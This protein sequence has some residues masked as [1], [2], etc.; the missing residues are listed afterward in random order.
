MFENLFVRPLFKSYP[1]RLLEVN[2]GAVLVGDKLD[3]RLNGD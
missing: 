1:I 2:E 3:V